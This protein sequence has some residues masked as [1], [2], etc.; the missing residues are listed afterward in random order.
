MSEIIEKVAKAIA[1]VIGH[2]MREKCVTHAQAAIAAYEGEIV[3]ERDAAHHLLNHIHREV[4]SL[5]DFDAASLMK[6]IEQTLSGSKI[7]NDNKVL[8]AERDRYKEA[9]ELIAHADAS[10]WP[11]C[12]AR[13]AARKALNP[14][15]EPKP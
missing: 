11:D 14:K 15:P 3:K 6:E 4:A 1:D 9:L 8:E 13:K 2:G 7:F 12:S 5:E 10:E